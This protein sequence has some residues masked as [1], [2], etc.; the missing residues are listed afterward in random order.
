M[1]VDLSKAFFID[2]RD[3]IGNKT[4]F[5]LVRILAK[6]HIVSTY[7][8]Q[9]LTSDMSV[10]HSSPTKAL[11]RAKRQI[12]QTSPKAKTTTSLISSNDD[13]NFSP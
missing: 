9:E 1:H 11:V 5:F 12:F 7:L 13:H 10:V 3:I 6:T 4:S 2:I 8:G